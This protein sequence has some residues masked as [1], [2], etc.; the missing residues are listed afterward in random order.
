MLLIH[1][2]DEKKDENTDEIAIKVAEK[3]GVRI[4]KSNVNRSHRLGPRKKP[5]NNVPV[6]PRPIILSLISYE[7]KKAIYDAKKKLKGT[8]TVITESLTKDRFD[9]YQKCRSMCGNTNTWTYDGKIWCW[10]DDE[11]VCVESD[12]DLA[13]LV[14]A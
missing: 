7:H 3:V 9:L 2:I 12:E 13:Q 1:G 14:E 8:K 11:K 6:K 5:S 10:S 4:T